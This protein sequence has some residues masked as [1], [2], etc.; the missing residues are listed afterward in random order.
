MRKTQSGPD[1]AG[2]SRFLGHLIPQLASA[3]NRVL[4]IE[5]SVKAALGETSVH[6]SAAFDVALETRSL[7]NQLETIKISAE[8]VTDG[9]GVSKPLAPE[10]PAPKREPARA[11]VEQPSPEEEEEALPPPPAAAPKEPE[12]APSAGGL[13]KLNFGIP[14]T[15]GA[16]PAAPK[17]TQMRKK[18]LG[19]HEEGV[20]VAMRADNCG[21]AEIAK[22]LDNHDP[23][24]FRTVGYACNRHKAHIAALKEIK[25][26]QPRM[27]YIAK[28]F[29]GFGGL[30]REK[31]EA[32]LARLGSKY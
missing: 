3:C 21:A 12:P 11:E 32:D 23:G 13:F 26:G 10:L 25:A 27:Q 22:E 17:A 14:P 7:L 28:W 9:L 30:P 6:F 20:I 5:N 8:I 24:F 4:T 2:I 19:T 18:V 16:K 29:D 1:E 15:N 31:R